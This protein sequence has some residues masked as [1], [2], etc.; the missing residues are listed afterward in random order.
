MMPLQPSSRSSSIDLSLHIQQSVNVIKNSHISRIN[1]PPAKL[2][3]PGT[4]EA[5]SRLICEKG[6]E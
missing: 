4:G 2:N 1:G 3:Q 6:A 5:Y